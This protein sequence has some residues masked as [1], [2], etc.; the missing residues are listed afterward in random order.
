MRKRSQCVTM[1]HDPDRHH[2][3]PNKPTSLQHGRYRARP[4][5][6]PQASTTTTQTTGGQ[7]PG[8]RAPTTQSS[9]P[10]TTPPPV[11]GPRVYIC[12]HTPVRLDFFWPYGEYPASGLVLHNLNAACSRRRGR[13]LTYMPIFWSPGWPHCSYRTSRPVRQQANEESA[14]AQLSEARAG[15]GL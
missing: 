9:Q 15:V 14:L 5:E 3:P 6:R 13:I 2:T 12:I 7:T 8:A 4:L 1:H 10:T 11:R